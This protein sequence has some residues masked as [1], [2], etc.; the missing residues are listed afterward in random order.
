VPFS[1]SQRGEGAGL[2]GG[3]CIPEDPGLTRVLLNQPT[4]RCGCAYA[5]LFEDNNRFQSILISLR[6]SGEGSSFE[7]WEF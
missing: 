7:L 2:Y 4:L 3:D 1:H 6:T 5:R